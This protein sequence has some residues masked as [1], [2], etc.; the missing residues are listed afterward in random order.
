MT[1][2]L[3]LHFSKLAWRLVR[4]P[5]KIPE[6]MRFQQRVGF[7]ADPLAKALAQLLANL[8]ARPAL[9]QESMTGLIHELML[10]T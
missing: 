4:S 5:G 9:P 6:L 7:A 1:A 3:K 10:P 2:E 8:A